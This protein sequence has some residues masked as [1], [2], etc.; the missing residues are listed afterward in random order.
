MKLFINARFLTQS[1]SGVQRYAIECSRQIKELYPESVFITPKNIVNVE[2]AKELGAVVVGSNTGHLWEQIDL[3]LYLFKKKS[4]KLLSLANTAPLMYSNNFIAI[5]DLAFYHHPEWNSKGF[6]TWY[7]ILIPRLAIHARH[8]FTVSQ[9][10]CNELVTY[11]KIPRNK[12]S[13]TYN[14]ISDDLKADSDNFELIKEKIILSV[15]TF[16]KRKNQQNLV[17][18]FLKSDIQ[19]EYTLVLVGD[20]NKIFSDSGIGDDELGDNIKIYQRLTDEE[21]KT[22]YERAEVVVSLSGYEGFGIPMLEGLFFGSKI[23][24]SDIPVYR[25]LFEQYA[26]FCNPL[27]IDNVAQQLS[28]VVTERRRFDKESINLLLEKYNYR[29]AAEVILSKMK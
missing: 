25:E 20:K 10:I 28:N 3:P 22:L 13:V 11:Y 24:C 4:P 12:I 9:T 5:H 1:I 16:N 17:K 21:L 6:S 15:G 27:Q 8:L 7:N 26:V 2:V 18:A 19:K 29:K 23:L 14:G